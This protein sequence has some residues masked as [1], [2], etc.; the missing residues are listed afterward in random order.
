MTD[1]AGL[2]DAFRRQGEACGALGSPI[3]AELCRVAAEDLEA[4]GAVADVMGHW[5]GRG[6]PME[7]ALPLRLLG[8]AHR[9]ALLGRA[10]GLAEHF[11]ACGGVPGTGMAPAFLEVVRGETVE[12]VG[13]LGRPV[14]TNEVGRAAVLRPGL[15]VVAD[16]FGLPIRLFEIGS[17]AG[18]NLRLDRFSYRLGGVVLPGDGPHLEPD[19]SGPDPPS[20]DVSVV[21]RRGCDPWAI[22]VT[23][24]DGAAR[25]ESFVWPD[26][27]WRFERMAAAVE[28]ARRVPVRLDRRA[29]GEWLGDHLHPE[30]GAATV[31]MHS[32]MWQYVPPDEQA[33]IQSLLSTRAEGA[34]VDAPM[35][36]LRFEPRFVSPGDWRFELRLRTWPGG[37]DRCLARA[38]PH[39][40]W[41]RW[42]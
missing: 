32:V 11:P 41:V 40:E 18:L 4:G 27:L 9:L 10:P 23:T 16:V 39:G 19:W 42:S 2:A 6:D 38:H 14:Q 12:F 36:H 35:A 29:A 21:D 1:V 34:T 33:A 7:L 3:Y 30:V 8:T 25:A 31:L 26:M 5:D 37:P 28:V 15:G 17:S 24:V 13:D 20:A 22:D